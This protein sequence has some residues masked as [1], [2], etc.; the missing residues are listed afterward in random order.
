M[1]HIVNDKDKQD[2]CQWCGQ[3]FCVGDKI[4]EWPRGTAV[5]HGCNKE[6]IDEQRSAKQEDSK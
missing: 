4:V 1:S 6:Y 5:H 3:P 2:D